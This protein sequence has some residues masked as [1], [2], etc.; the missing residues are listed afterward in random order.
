M[1]EQVEKKEGRLKKWGKRAWWLHSLGALLFGVGVMI[2]AR[3][4]LAYA[5]KI[6]V[7]LGVSW[8]LVFVAFRFIVGPQNRGPEERKTKK[9]LRV[10]TNYI[11]KQFYQQIFFFL[12]PIYF[13]SATWQMNDWSVANWFMVPVL[14]VFAVLSTLDLVFDNFIM[15]RK[16]VA[17]LIYGVGLFSV[18][19][20]LF[21]MLTGAS[22]FW[23]LMFAAGVTPLAVALLTLTM[24][25]AFSTRGIV[26]LATTT[27]MFAT[28]VY[29]VR[30]HIPPVPMVMK[31]AGVG[32]GTLGEFECVPGHKNH[33][34]L[35]NATEL[36]C[37]T[38]VSAPGGI[39]DEL[40]HVW[41]KDGT[42]VGRI[43]VQR[44]GSCDREGIVFRTY[45]R[46]SELALPPERIG[47]W[48]CRLAT[49]LDQTVGQVSFSIT[50]DPEP[51]LQPTESPTTEKE[52]APTT[53]SDSN[54]VYGE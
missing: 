34:A 33:I 32:H 47:K 15:E 46:D 29:F 41:S 26:W 10:V 38:N 21:P 23:G 39:V 44:V 6:L 37:G 35:G 5:D 27:L 54:A 14:L 16:W 3:K 48:T 20:L 28:G 25:Q 9:G 31:V 24:K 1:S 7:G 2:F 42:E 40:F 18:L 51:I 13:F 43:P 50:D 52:V 49:R 53:E 19:N 4:G 17:S 8:L 11:I 45:L 12:T 36:R 30:V 22:H